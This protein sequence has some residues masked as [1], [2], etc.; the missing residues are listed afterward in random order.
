MK[1]MDSKHKDSIQVKLLSTFEIDHVRGDDGKRSE[2]LGVH[3]MRLNTNVGIII[4][5][6]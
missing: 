1:K 5:A 3:F 2:G 4:A 6:N